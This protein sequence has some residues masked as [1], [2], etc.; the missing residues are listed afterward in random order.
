MFHAMTPKH[1]KKPITTQVGNPESYLRCIIC[2]SAFGMGVNAKG[3]TKSIHYGAP[4]T[5][6][7]L[8][9]KSLEEY[10]AMV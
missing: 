6:E 7:T 9:F 5:I 4:S 10:V 2:T 8:S 1:T 3:F